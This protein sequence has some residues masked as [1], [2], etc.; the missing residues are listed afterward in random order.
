MSL[1]LGG[2]FGWHLL[3]FGFAS[4]LTAGCV[5]WTYRRRDRH[6]AVA[7]L[8]FLVVVLLWNLVVLARILGPQPVTRQ[9][10]AVEQFVQILTPVVWCYFA[11]VYTGNRAWLRRPAVRA[12]LGALVV[13][14]LTVESVPP[15][16]AIAFTDPVV[17]EQPFVFVAWS[18]TVLAEAI[19]VVALSFAIA[20]S[21]LILYTLLTANYVRAWQVG[22]VFVS[23]AGAIL[24]EL[25]ESSIPNAVPGVDYP[26][27]AVAGI[28]V[29][30]LVG[31]YRYDLFGYTPVDMT[32]VIDSITAPVVALNPAGRVTDFNASAQEVFPDLARGAQARTAL[33]APVV[34]T[35]SLE[36]ITDREPEVTLASDG[37]ERTYRL[38]TA[39]LDSFGDSSGLAVTFRDVTTRRR[40]QEQLDL[41]NQI[42]RRALRHNV[43]NEVDV[44]K[45][46][47]QAVAERVD[48]DERAL[49]LRAFEA[50]D[51]LGSLSAKTQTL[52][53]IVQRRH[54]SRTV[55]MSALL[56]GVVDDYREQFPETTIA[57]SCPDECRIEVTAGMRAAVENLIENAAEHNTAADPEVT[58]TLAE[59]AGAVEIE[60]T[61]NGPGIPEAELTVLDRGR[62]TMLEHGSGVGLWVV[63]L[64]VA[65]NDGT[66]EYDIGADGSTITIKLC[67]ENRDR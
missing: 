37:E 19:E 5:V 18:D 10:H 28:G 65:E 1:G 6:A 14:M 15:L 21:G 55:D 44:V 48:A 62:E 56:E 63:N 51:S 25:F 27:L 17:I 50:A 11:V 7:F 64:A 53:D 60:V 66:V 42:L 2:V 23:T 13:G 3:V 41:L 24:L 67:R 49:A 61:D 35:V 8:T 46:N 58:V 29:S 34:E 43:R 40:Q 39:P 22:V 57:L 36:G 38:Y 12:L 31:L 20:G 30:Y 54:T 32:D 26:A 45:A 52:T 47:T 9:L 4:V 59:R 33:P 16:H